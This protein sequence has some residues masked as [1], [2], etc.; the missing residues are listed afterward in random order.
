MS[1]DSL[2]VISSPERV[3]SPSPSSSHE[4]NE[5]PM[6]TRYLINIE[7]DEKK[8][9]LEYFLKKGKELPYQREIKGFLAD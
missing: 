9:K 7:L 6:D 8:V 3:S 4:Y 1:E 2:E 5:C